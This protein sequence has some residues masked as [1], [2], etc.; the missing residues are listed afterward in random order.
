MSTQSNHRASYCLLAA[1]TCG[2]EENCGK[3]LWDRSIENIRYISR[4]IDNQAG[5]SSGTL[6][7]RGRRANR[8][9]MEPTGKGWTPVFTTSST[10][11]FFFGNLTYGFVDNRRSFA[12]NWIVLH[13][14][15]SFV[16]LFLGGTICPSLWLWC[17]SSDTGDFK[18]IYFLNLYIF[19]NVYIQYIYSHICI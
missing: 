2:L 3:K 16:L 12:I 5:G 6:C 9:T 8:C 13:S 4:T 15:S 17:T 19:Y 18:R 14:H 7:F 10:Y 1:A 11:G